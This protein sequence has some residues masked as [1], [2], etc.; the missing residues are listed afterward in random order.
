AELSPAAE[1]A[2]E[3]GV[4]M[5]GVDN[6]RSAGKRLVD[7][8]DQFGLIVIAKVTLDD[9]ALFINQQGGWCH[10][11]I[12]KGFGKTAVAVHDHGEGKLTRTREIAYIRF[13]V[14]LHG[15]GDGFKSL[16]RQCLVA[17]NGCWHLGDTSGAVRCP[18]F[19]QHDLATKFLSRDGLTVKCIEGDIRCSVTGGV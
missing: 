10:L 4:M 3:E 5:M 1:L 19:D 12:T 16:R 15:D 8:R 18:E 9:A 11:Y 6:G 2:W 14:V 17:I 13:R 7:G